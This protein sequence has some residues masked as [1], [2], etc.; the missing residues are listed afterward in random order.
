MEID[1]N[2]LDQQRNEYQRLQAEAHT[3]PAAKKGNSN[4]D[5]DK[6]MPAKEA[7]STTKKPAA[8]KE[9]EIHGDKKIPSSRTAAGTAATSDILPSL[10]DL[11]LT[12]E[13]K[14]LIDDHIIPWL[15]DNDFTLSDDGTFSSDSIIPPVM[16][17][18]LIRGGARIAAAPPSVASPAITNTTGAPPRRR[19]NTR[20]SQNGAVDTTQGAIRVNRTGP[21]HVDHPVFSPKTNALM[22]ENGIRIVNGIIYAP[23][24]INKFLKRGWELMLKTGKPYNSCAPPSTSSEDSDSTPPK[25]NQKKPAIARKKPASKQPTGNNA[26]SPSLAHAPPNRPTLIDPNDPNTVFTGPPPNAMEAEVNAWADLWIRHHKFTPG[27]TTSPQWVQTW[28]DNALAHFTRQTAVNASSNNSDTPM[29]EETQ[30]APPAAAAAHAEPPPQQLPAKR[31]SPTANPEDNHPSNTAET[32]TTHDPPAAV[33]ADTNPSGT[34]ENATIEIDAQGDTVEDPI[35]IDESTSNSD[36]DS[37]A[38][39]DTST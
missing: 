12:K 11:F 22:R 29:P 17:Q 34:A 36:N 20:P 15:R 16:Q 10:D 3:K 23:E 1:I 21:P 39:M 2:N 6:K 18:W 27:S 30:L 13:E 4:D 19:P 37:A 33:A 28:I 14:E 8:K 32:T 35:V 7:R 5:E 25:R 24:G 9:T 31:K 26:M 38:A